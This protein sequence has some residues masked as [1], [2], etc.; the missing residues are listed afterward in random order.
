MSRSAGSPLANIQPL[1]LQKL[2]IKGGRL[3]AMI[4]RVPSN[5]H[6]RSTGTGTLFWS[7]ILAFE[8]CRHFEAASPQRGKKEHQSRSK[9]KQHI[10]RTT[11]AK[12]TLFIGRNWSAKAILCRQI[13]F[14][15]ATPY[16]TT[17]RTPSTPATDV[18]LVPLQQTRLRLLQR[19]ERFGNEASN[20]EGRS[21]ISLE[22]LSV[23]A[24]SDTP[25]LLPT[26]N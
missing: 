2:Y 15:V 17:L 12:P 26:P 20:L 7:R 13:Q 19:H 10:F 25:R 24:T 5:S 21:D 14:T 4:V 11:K 9:Q 23:V 6:P 22:Q 16:I 18:T 3:F 1:S 8:Q